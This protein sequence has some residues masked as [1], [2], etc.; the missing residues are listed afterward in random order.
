MTRRVDD[1]C[2]YLEG[3][4]AV[5]PDPAPPV[6]NTLPPSAV[7]HIARRPAR[8]S[9]RQIWGLVRASVAAWGEDYASS[10]GAALSFYTVFSVAPV[11]LSAI[12]VAG[13]V[14][15][16][17]AAQR[18]VASQ[19]TGLMGREA[20]AAVEALLQSARSPSG[21]VISTTVG[22]VVLLIGAS[23]VFGEL[24]DALNRIWRAP[25]PRPP[26]LWRL[27]TERILSFG[28][29]LGV[30]FLLIVSLVV[31]AAIA[32]FG[33]YRER[34][35]PAAAAAVPRHASAAPQ[36][37]PIL[38]KPWSGGLAAERRAGRPPGATPPS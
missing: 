8:M 20:A 9:A 7:R 13:L 21:G 23:A 27:V 32:A 3:E 2:G 11:L 37:T 12:A 33:P 35:Q 17:H 15:D 29:I 16:T 38:V 1:D 31:S 28:M 19:L 24:Q 6:S 14:F 18:A 10:M 36:E 22:V 26:G 34:P 25:V 4:I 5:T 30:G